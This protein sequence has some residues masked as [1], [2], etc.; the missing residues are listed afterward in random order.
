MVTEHL[1]LLQKVH[2][3]SPQNSQKRDLLTILL[4]HAIQQTQTILINFNFA[5]KRAEK[6]YDSLQ[7]LSRSVELIQLSLSQPFRLM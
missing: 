1:P 4:L 7:L 3:N 2:K 5:G 6:H